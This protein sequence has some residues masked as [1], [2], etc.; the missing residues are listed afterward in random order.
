VVLLL[1][2][3]AP[4]LALAQYYEYLAVGEIQTVQAVDEN[5]DPIAGFDYTK[6]NNAGVVAGAAAS[7]S[8]VIDSNT[9]PAIL[10]PPDPY[11]ARY[12]GAYP[13]FT[14]G[15][16]T[17]A[18]MVVNNGILIY[19]E[20]PATEEPPV[21]VVHDAFGYGGT[22]PRSTTGPSFLRMDNGTCEN[23]KGSAVILAA[24]V[25]QLVSSTALPTS[26]NLANANLARTMILDVIDTEANQRYTVTSSIDTLTIDLDAADP[27]PPPPEPVPI[28]NGWMF[29]M[30]G[31]FMLLVGAVFLRGA[32][33]SEA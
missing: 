10:D 29:G 14:A 18:G 33:R 8:T 21:P 16:F 4:G 7:G 5:Y 11:A 30:L 15:T 19:D 22:W 31:S 2:L 1:A 20:H 12:D 25:L 9:P 23:R 17:V 24:T 13:T 32:R 28:M 3:G 6:I 27:P 26:I